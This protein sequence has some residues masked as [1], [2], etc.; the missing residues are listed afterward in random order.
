MKAKIKKINENIVKLRENPKGTIKNLINIIKTYIVKNKLFVAFVIL[1][2]FNSTALRFVT[3]TT[4]EN[5]L[6]LKPILADLSFAIIIG[7]FCYLFKNKTKQFIYLFTLTIILT[8]LCTINSIYYTFYTSFASISM[9]PL[10]QF[11]IGV[12]DAIVE[13]VISV[14]DVIYLIAPIGMLFIYFYKKEKL[15]PKVTN[16]K[17]KTKMFKTALVG[18]VLFALFALSLS[19]LE[20]GRFANQWNREYI[21]MRFGIYTYQLNDMVQS[22]GPQISS[23]FGYDQALKEVKEYYEE[24]P[25][26]ESDNEYTDVLKGKNII[27]IH[28][29]SIQQFVI[30]MEFNGEPVT[31][32]LNKLVEEG[33]SFTNFYS[34]V[35]VGT[36]SDTEL[37]LATSLMPTLNGTAFVSYFDREYLTT[38]D[39]LKEQGYYIFSMHGNTGDFWNRRVMHNNFGYDRFYSKNDYN[40]TKENTIGLGISDVDFFDQSI[41]YIEE[42]AAQGQ[43]YYGTMIMLSNHTPFSDVDKYGEY[44]VDIKEEVIN[45]DGTTTIVSY[46]YMEGT[47]LGNYIK[48]VRYA[49]M[50]LGMFLEDLDEKGLLENTAIV[51]Y[52]DHDAR[53]SSSDYERL[54]NYDKTTDDLIPE[55]DPT[56]FEMDDYQYELNRKVPFIIWTKDQIVTGTNDNV[57][58]MY[59]IQPTLGNMM[60]FYNEYQLGHDIFETEEDNIVVFPNGNWLTNKVYY[61]AQ[62]REFLPLTEE[63]IS[64]EYIE[65]KTLY[66]ESLLSASNNIIVY[67]L[68]KGMEEIETVGGGEINETEKAR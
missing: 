63:V 15:N 20:I 47:K 13:N 21:V 65:E 53:L 49:D 28:A 29:E 36:S 40:V 34:Q 61:N 1:T 7:S 64:Q 68:I 62:K 50:A 33:L 59:D 9:L 24:N 56:Y 30:G 54:Y 4:L 14:K 41:P 43:P 10:M 5:Y 42:I 37:T 39:L 58:G 27:A 48:S 31:P 45:E 26:E 38:Y 16:V 3:M 6:S 19:S 44:P 2:V 52:G 23:L 22:V 11:A 12:G 57:M 32:T 8:A 67:D 60:G 55:D 17:N 46:P 18:G 25:N 35:S 66:T 51:I